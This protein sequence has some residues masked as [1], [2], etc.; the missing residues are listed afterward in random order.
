MLVSDEGRRG[1]HAAAG[2]VREAGGHDA[3]PFGMDSG[4]YAEARTCPREDRRARRTRTAVV[5]PALLLSGYPE[6]DVQPYR[7][8][9]RLGVLIV[10]LGWE[11]FPGP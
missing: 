1:R 7:G 4:A 11:L 5:I 10:C 3:N 2:A 6:K 8:S 9:I